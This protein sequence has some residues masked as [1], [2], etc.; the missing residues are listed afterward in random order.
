MSTNRLTFDESWSRETL[1]DSCDRVTDGSHFSPPP[2]KI[3][4]P[5]VNVKDLRHGFVDIDSCTKIRENDF[6]RLY[7]NECDVIKNDVLFSKDGTIGKVVV[8]CQD[9]ELVA[10]S[11]LAILR[12]SHKLDPSYLGY[13]MESDDVSKQIEIHSSGSALR[14]LVLREIKRIKISYPSR[15]EKQRAISNIL[16]IIDANLYN[17]NSVIEKINNIKFGLVHDLLTFGITDNGVIRDPIRESELFNNHPQLGCIPRQWDA[18]TIE[19]ISKHVGSGIT[20]TGGSEVYTFRGVLFVRSQ[21]VTFDGLKLN[22]VAYI[23]QKIHLEMKNSEIFPNDILLNITG[24]SIGRCCIFP[25]G[26]GP[27]NVNQHVCAIRLD[28][29]D[30]N[31][32]KFINEFLAS[33][34]GQNQIYRLNAGSNRQG[35]NYQQVRSIVIPWP[36]DPEEVK[37]IISNITKIK[38][39]L[40]TEIQVRDKLYLL[41]KGLMQDLL[42]GRVPLPEELLTAQGV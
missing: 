34:L 29:P 40:I 42:T 32:A 25:E 39:S 38:Q 22:D 1:K 27:A 36:K 35:L 11:S 12:P 31:R 19:D 16:G 21:N 28:E 2:Q 15:I 13:S 9:D 14:R 37:Q 5:I 4:R 8:Y 6:L 17:F 23:P 24:A 18:R 20:P 41:K 33:P 7:Q 30:E 26:M 3:G 10:L